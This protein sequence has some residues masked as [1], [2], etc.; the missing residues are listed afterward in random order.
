MMEQIPSV[1]V[2][3]LNWNNAPAT[4]ACL[5]SVAQVEYPNYRVLVVDNGSE[6]GSVDQI[7]TVWPEV[8]LLETGANLGYAGGNNVGIRCA[9]AMGAEYICLLNNDVVV[10]PTFLRELVRAALT[11]P[12]VALLG[13]KILAPGFSGLLSPP[14]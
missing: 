12:Q 5:D 8:E 9:L 1:V 7:R 2:V 4:L 11:D 13:P 3:I 14:E 10:E 6:D